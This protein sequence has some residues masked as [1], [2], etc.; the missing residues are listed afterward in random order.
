MARQNMGWLLG[1]AVGFLALIGVGHPL[2]PGTLQSRLPEVPDHHSAARGLGRRL[3]GAGPLPVREA[4]QVLAPRLSPM[5]REAPRSRRPSGRGNGPVHGIGGLLLRLAGEGDSSES[6]VPE[7]LAP[8][9][10]LPDPGAAEA[11]RR[12]R[13][14]AGVLGGMSTVNGKVFDPDRIDARPRL[15]STEIWEISGDPAHPIH[16]HLVHFRV[17]SRDGGPPGPYD[18]GWKDTVFLEGGTV[19]VAA[20]FDSYRGKY[21]FHCHNLEHEDMMMSNFEVI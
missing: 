1:A 16:L 5:G 3:P 21:V 4:D 6:A 10:D 12:F 17:L 8:D 15:G 7:R 14:I 20:R 9:L 19:R 13:F 18:A 11:T 2:P